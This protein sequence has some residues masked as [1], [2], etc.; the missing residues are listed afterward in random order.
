M[1][2]TL[3]VGGDLP[4][5]GRNRF[6]QFKVEQCVLLQIRG[7]DLG[8]ETVDPFAGGMKFAVAYIGLVSNSA[9]EER[10]SF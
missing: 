2:F 3:K 1:E 9:T 5:Q 7:K 4:E 6:A 8:L 10:F